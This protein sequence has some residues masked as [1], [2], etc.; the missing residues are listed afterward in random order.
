MVRWVAVALTYCVVTSAAAQ[1]V[2]DGSDRQI[3]DPDRKALIEVLTSH[4]RDP[5]GSQIQGLKSVGA[6]KFCGGLNTKNQYGA[7]IGFRL[8]GV[9]LQNQNFAVAPERDP[10]DSAPL[11]EK[12]AALKALQSVQAIC[13]PAN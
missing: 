2:V 1:T 5:Y 8:F 11:S 10:P 3:N 13:K 12:T 7:Y 4:L 6:S 9:D